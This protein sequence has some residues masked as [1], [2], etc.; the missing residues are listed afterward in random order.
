MVFV[1]LIAVV[2]LG[3]AGYGVYKYFLPTSG[4]Q[5]GAGMVSTDGLRIVNPTGAVEANGDL[6]ISGVIENLTDKERSGWY[7]VV[8]VYDAQGK[9]LNKIRLLNGKQLYTRKDYDVLAQRGRN[10]QELKTQLLQNQGVAIPAKG[11]VPF[12]M[13]Y[14]QPP[15]GIASFNATLQPFDP[16]RLIKEIEEDAK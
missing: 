3:A 6:I 1:A 2:L 4:D 15:S 16:A 7:V 9:V 13:R 8:D 5:S 11:S 12:E 10:V 14:L